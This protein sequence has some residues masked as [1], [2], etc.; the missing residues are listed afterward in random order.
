MK[1]PPRV[2]SLV[3]LLGLALGGTGILFGQADSL[4]ERARAGDPEAVASYQQRFRDSHDVERKKDI[5]MFLAWAGRASE[6]HVVFLEAHGCEAVRSSRPYPFAIDAGGDP[7]EPPTYSAE[8]VAWVETR[9]ADLEEEARIAIREQPA[10]VLRLRSLEDPRVDAVLMAGL[11]S[12]N[13]AVAL[14]SVSA[15]VQHGHAEAVPA[16]LQAA[17]AMP[18]QVRLGVGM[19]LLR[20]LDARADEAARELIADDELYRKL[21][22]ALRP[23]PEALR[24]TGSEAGKGERP[25]APRLAAH[26]GSAMVVAGSEVRFSCAVE[27]TEAVTFRWERDGVPMVDGRRVSGA[28]TPTLTLFEV[29][30][31][32]S[33]TYRCVAQNELGE[34]ASAPGILRVVV[35]A[36][37]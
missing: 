30:P 7:V 29:Y 24:P 19:A 35:P 14:E 15:L 31:P 10:E 12:P 1:P 6:E 26:P 16:I 20:L 32:D 33:G 22:D 18:A 9:S 23:R 25:G 34:A 4:T 17:S 3:C 11:F 5:A 21:R 13:H 8:F 28:E 36:D 27:G 2:N 37:P